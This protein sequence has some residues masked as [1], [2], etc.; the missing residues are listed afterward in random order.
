MQF[1][2]FQ[3]R[4]FTKKYIYNFYHFQICPFLP[5][6]QQLFVRLLFSVVFYAKFRVKIG[7]IR[8]D[9]L[10]CCR[11][12]MRNFV[13]VVLLIP[14]NNF[15][16]WQ[17]AKTNVRRGADIEF[18]ATLH[19]AVRLRLKYAQFKHFWI[20]GTHQFLHYITKCWKINSFCLCANSIFLSLLSAIRSDFFY[21][22][23][24]QKLFFFVWTRIWKK[25]K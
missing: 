5:H 11:P 14:P 1:L 10:R 21:L 18:L 15:G 6:Q 9:G 4:I 7:K 20:F 23:F 17:I 19:F 16:R 2:H 13:D 22:T 25:A 3:V 24:G 12:P 8:E